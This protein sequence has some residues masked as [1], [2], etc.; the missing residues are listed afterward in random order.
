MT[1]QEAE[2]Q[3][4]E[5]GTVLQLSPESEEVRP[6]FKGCFLVV[7]EVKTWGIQGYIPAVGA[8]FDEPGGLVFLRPKWEDLEFVGAAVWRSE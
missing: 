1:Q 8:T 7:T 6:C 4:V 2:Q 5:V 3:P